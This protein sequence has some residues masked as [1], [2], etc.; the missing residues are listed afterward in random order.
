MKSIGVKTGSRGYFRGVHRKHQEDSILPLGTVLQLKDKQI[1]LNL[2]SSA[3]SS[4][5]QIT[6][7][8]VTFSNDEHD[9]SQVPDLERAILVE[10]LVLDPNLL[11]YLLELSEYS[12]GQPKVLNED[13][14]LRHHYLV[15]FHLLD[16]GL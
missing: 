6:S 10:G 5:H 4:L 3:K 12:H 13:L 14:A 2:L 16:E 7:S 8:I 11:P 1:P 9:P 15:Q